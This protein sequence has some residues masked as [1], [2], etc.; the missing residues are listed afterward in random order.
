MDALTYLFHRVF[1]RQI[2]CSRC[3]KY[4]YRS[5]R[6]CPY[7]SRKKKGKRKKGV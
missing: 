1:Y 2:R 3:G 6:R 7:C 4:Y 5:E